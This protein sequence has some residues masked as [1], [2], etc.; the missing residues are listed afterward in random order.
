MRASNPTLS[1]KAL[2]SAGLHSAQPMT[3]QGTVNKSAFFLSLVAVPAVM[4]WNKVSANPAAAMPWIIGSMIVGLI[5]CLITCF[6][7][8]WAA[9]T[10][11]VYALAE[12]VLLGAISAMY[13]AQF[14]GI[15]LQ[16]IL[17]TIGVFLALLAIY[18]LRLVRVTDKFKIGILAAT[19]SIALVYLVSMVLSF[20]GIQIPYI[21]GSGVIGIGFSVVVV[22]IAAMNL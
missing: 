20:F 5:F 10:G 8:E 11:S 13:E 16:A 2:S 9:V 22:I 15:V 6:K 4:T 3:L 17:L 7:K 21:H 14:Q 19:G 1:E 18:T 12:G